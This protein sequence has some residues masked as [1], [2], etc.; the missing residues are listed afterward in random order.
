MTEINNSVH[1]MWQRHGEQ[2]EWKVR[3]GD[4]ECLNWYP[5]EYAALSDASLFV[6]TDT[7]KRALDWVEECFDPRHDVRRSHKGLDFVYGN[8]GI[9]VKSSE[10]YRFSED[11]IRH[12]AILDAA[13]VLVVDEK[14]PYVHEVLD[15]RSFRAYAHG[16]GMEVDGE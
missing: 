6:L 8:F 1:Q 12:G 9:E 5:G 4:I 14:C 2:V 15:E 11:Q 16:R 3:D 13:I 10:N 7:E